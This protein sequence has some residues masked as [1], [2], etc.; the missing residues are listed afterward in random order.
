M[1]TREPW[2][3]AALA[4]SD[5]KHLM[6]DLGFAHRTT[7]DLV[8][9]NYLIP[10]GATVIG[11]HWYVPKNLV[12]VQVTLFRVRAIANDPEVFPNP[13]KFD[14]QRWFT[15]EGRLRDDLNFCTYGFGRR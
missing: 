4:H 3:C 11:N 7:T 1:A 9:E 13:D 12:R 5:T 14:P 10:K 2:R 8:W 6:H 15:A